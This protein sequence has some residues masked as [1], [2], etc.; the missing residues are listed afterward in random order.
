MRASLWTCP[1]SFLWRVQHFGQ[2][3]SRFLRS[4]FAL[5]RANVLAS[6]VDR[7]TVF[8]RGRRSIWGESVKFPASVFLAAFHHVPLSFARC[9]HSPSLGGRRR[10]NERHGEESEER[11]N[12]PLPRWFLPV[13][14]SPSS[15]RMPFGECNK[16]KSRSMSPQLARHT[17][18]PTLRTLHFHS[19]LHTLQ[20]PH[21]TFF[22]WPRL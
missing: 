9:A 10:K 12:G 5:T 21:S 11:V 7:D 15:L 19:T 2:V 1:C 6:M 17:L 3:V 22:A 20:T 13:C 4:T 8:F 16:V 14:S 18:H